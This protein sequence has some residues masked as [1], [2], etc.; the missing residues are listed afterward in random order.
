MCLL[1]YIRAFLLHCNEHQVPDLETAPDR[2]DASSSSVAD[3]QPK[4]LIQSHIHPDQHQHPR[5]E[6]VN[7]QII[8]RHSSIVTEPIPIVCNLPVNSPDQIIKAIARQQSEYKQ[9][10]GNQV[11]IYP[12]DI[13]VL[14]TE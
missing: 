1:K 12:D 5:L 7:D 4:S 13:L 10:F 6:Q 3:S 8:A 9:K 2:I 14:K 11:I